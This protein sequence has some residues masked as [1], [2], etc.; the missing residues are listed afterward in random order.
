MGDI[1]DVGKILDG[2]LIYTEKWCS[3]DLSVQLINNTLG[4]RVTFDTENTAIW[5]MIPIMDKQSLGILAT[6]VKVL[7]GWCCSLD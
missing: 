6:V 3:M 4:W 2:D 7:V 5:M 1:I